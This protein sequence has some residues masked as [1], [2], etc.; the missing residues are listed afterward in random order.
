MWD[1]TRPFVNLNQYQMS[2]NSRNLNMRIEKIKT[3]IRSRIKDEVSLRL[4]GS[5]AQKETPGG[6]SDNGKAA[7]ELARQ[8]RANSIQQA[9]SNRANSIKKFYSS[10]RMQEDE[11]TAVWDDLSDALNEDENLDLTKPKIDNMIDIL[12]K[13]ISNDNKKISKTEQRTNV[14]QAE[15]M[16]DTLNQV[17]EMYADDPYI[18][19]GADNTGSPASRTIARTSPDSPNSSP[20]SQ[21]SGRIG[22]A[23]T[24]ATAQYVSA[25]KNETRSQGMLSSTKPKEGRAEIRGEATFFKSIQDMLLHEAGKSDDAE[26][27]SGLRMLKTIMDRQKSALISDKRTNAG[28]IYLTQAEIDTILDSLFVAIDR[29]TER[30][31]Q[32]R[33]KL[34]A[35]FADIIAKS[36]MSTFIDKSVPEVNSRTIKKFN[37][38]GREVEIPLN[39]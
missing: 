21:G 20:V 9:L 4:P 15:K 11:H 22:R 24:R 2:E 32:D 14:R 18:R 1:M 35:D 3:D 16:R 12:N 34:L 6:N 10:T 7:S 19:N 37:R 38:G 29:Q 5:P 39:E 8:N 25:R 13:Y 28:A 30:G 27:S 31:G 26:V 36:A 33:A 23:P 17:S